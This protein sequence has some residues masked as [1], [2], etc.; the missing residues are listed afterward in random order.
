M[1]V[2]P[3]TGVFVFDVSLYKESLNWSLSLSIYIKK[4][5]IYNIYM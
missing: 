1:P 3:Q 2:N 4:L 5:Y